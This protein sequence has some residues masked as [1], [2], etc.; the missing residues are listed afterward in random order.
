V[1]PLVWSLALLALLVV[2]AVLLLRSPLLRERAAALLVARLQEYLGRQVEVGRVEAGL[3][4]LE[5]VIHDLVV[6]GES[7]TDTPL[8]V[9]PRLTVL[10]DLEGLRRPRLRLR[11]V[12]L[13]RPRLYLEFRADGTDNVPR[14]RLR[15]GGRRRV[16]VE[17]DAL[18]VAGGTL[19]IAER[20][21][22]LDLEAQAVAVELL[23]GS[24]TLLKGRAVAQEVEVTLPDA[25]PYRFSLAARGSVDR[26]R[27]EIEAARLS[28]PDLWADVTGTARWGAE[29]T[30]DLQVRGEA[31]SEL[32]VRLGYVQDQ[33]RGPFEIQG[34]FAWRPEAWGYRGSVTSPEAILLDRRLTGLQGVLSGDRHGVRFDVERAGYHGGEVRG[35]LAVEVPDPQRPADLELEFTGVALE[36]ALADQGIPVEGLAGRVDGSLRYRFSFRRPEEGSG[37]VELR[38]VEAPAT[39]RQVPIAGSA[40]LAIENGVLRSAAIQLRNGR[41]TIFAEGAYDLERSSGQF[42]FN[43]ESSDLAEL[44]LLLPPP[45]PGEPPA[46]WVPTRGSGS[47]SGTLFLA[48]SGPAAEVRLDLA[49]VET[50]GLRADRV[51]G[52]LRVDERWVDDLRLDMSRAAGALL[53]TGRVPL[54]PEGGGPP[55]GELRVA[56]EAESWPVEEARAW[57]PEELVDLPVAGRFSG[58][59]ALQGDLESP[60][61]AIAGRLE[62]AVYAG[63]ALGGV[64]AALDWDT[65]Q[66]RVREVEADTAAGTVAGRGTLG[67]HDE[68]LDFTLEAPALRLGEAPLSDYLGR[69]L[70]GSL[71]LAVRVGGTL[72]LPRVEAQIDAAELVL[73]GRSLGADGGARV[74]ASWSGEELRASGSLLGLVEFSGGGG[75]DRERAGLRFELVSDQLAG[76]VD[77]LV[78]RPLPAFTGGFAGVLEIDGPL[79]GESGPRVE[80]RLDRLSAEYG[81]RALANREPVVARLDRRGVEVRS[82]YLGEQTAD[83]EL[84]LAGRV[85]L[86]QPADLDLRVQASLA[87][88]WLELVA[89]QVQASGHFEL[90]AAIRGSS[91]RPEVSGQGGLRDTRLIVL[92]FPH[93]FEQLRGTVLFYPNELVVDSLSAALGGGT[94]RAGGRIGLAEAG[95]APYTFQLEAQRVSLRY[96]EGWLLRGDAELAVVSAA[97]G[98]QVRG[99]V[100]LDRAYYLRDMPTTLPRLLRTVLQRQRLQMA[101]TEELLASTQ[102]NVA[103]TAPGTLRLRNNLADLRGSADL[104]L[105]GTLAA[106]VVFGQVEIEAGGKVVYAENEYVV[107]RALV[108]FANPYR[109]EPFLD[110]VARTEVNQYQVTLNLSGTL[111]RL[112]ATFASDPPIADLEIF[113]LLAGG[114]P[115]TDLFDLTRERAPGEQSYGAETFLAGQAATL[116]GQRV[117]TLFGFDKFRVAPLAAGGDAISSVRLTVGKRLS[118]DLLLTYSVDPSATQEQLATV[119]WQVDRG[120]SLVFTQNGDGSYAV[121]ARWEKRF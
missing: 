13:E 73:G 56:V 94:V 17:I 14:P 29:R 96:P 72:E 120:L 119:E 77:L 31:T 106:P 117:N 12:H 37:W 86:G 79:G 83:S 74:T 105:R 103:V 70:Q 43:A 34:G 54:P 115:D 80:V 85:A 57:F 64:R 84:F 67:L 100:E 62:Q 76:I 58:T 39:G 90:L 114:E 25:R 55:P 92:G 104:A 75:L 18:R 24:T 33:A 32:F 78:E 4:P 60:S 50:P 61:G 88:D 46:L 5:L 48:P 68:R 98:R 27:V 63:V 107:E 87:C 16:Q 3:L 2:A 41:Q 45:G 111:D 112:N 59:V 95:P 8:L 26:G 49:E 97:G 11:D 28:G 19:E 21:L 51:R 69:E 101:E 82:L 110:L 65:E 22:P 42:T 52:S 89:P 113:G 99:A 121:D 20:R 10:A 116:L 91:D 7:A 71:A 118:K 30:V 53:I 108:T 93:A 15:G 40:P 81:G 9:V 36:P 1:R 35:S 47:L 66:V 109:V 102:L 23:A 38:I 44:A 6:P